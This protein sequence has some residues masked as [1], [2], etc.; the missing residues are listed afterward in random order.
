MALSLGGHG[1]QTGRLTCL[2]ASVSM[3]QMWLKGLEPLKKSL[4]V[5]RDTMGI[6]RGEIWGNLRGPMLRCVLACLIGRV[7]RQDK[8]WWS[9]LAQ[10]Q[11][12]FG[13]MRTREPGLEGCVLISFLLLWQTATKSTQGVLGGQDVFGSHFPMT[14]Q[15]RRKSGQECKQGRNLEAGADGDYGGVLPTDLLMACLAGF[16][17]EPRTTCPGVALPTVGCALPH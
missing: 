4:R 13:V 5:C 14:V 6:H 1:V 10:R 7:G 12:K 2:Q 9:K 11:N 3:P 17:I 8:A 16:L 15:H